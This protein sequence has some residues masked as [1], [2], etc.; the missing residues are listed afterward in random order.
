M[1]DLARPSG[2]SYTT[3]GEELSRSVTGKPSGVPQGSSSSHLFPFLSGSAS[4][5]TMDVFE[6]ASSG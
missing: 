4:D 6:N 3:V 2:P 5:E 1:G